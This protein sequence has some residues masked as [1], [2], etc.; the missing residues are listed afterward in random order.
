[1]HVYKIRVCIQIFKYA[2]KRM[3]ACI[4][5][6]VYVYKYSNTRIRGKGEKQPVIKNISKLKI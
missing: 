3:Y 4:Q 5:I 6:F 1:M 2:N